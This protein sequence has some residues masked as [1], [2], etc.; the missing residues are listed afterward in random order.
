MVNDSYRMKTPFRSFI[1][2]ERAKTNSYQKTDYNFNG[3]LELINRNEN[4]PSGI[5]GSTESVD[6]SI[7]WMTVEPY[8]VLIVE[9]KVK[10]R[11]II[12]FCRKKAI[13][14]KKKKNS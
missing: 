5:I 2:N 8:T 4:H 13:F 11:M 12:N 10:M 3:N 14:G 7:W 1:D 6:L 9:I